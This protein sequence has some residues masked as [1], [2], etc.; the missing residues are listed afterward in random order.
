MLEY[1]SA[2]TA[3]A[4]AGTLQC[5]GSRETQESE[6]ERQDARDSQ[7]TTGYGG[8]VGPAQMVNGGEIQGHQSRGQ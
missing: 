3:R 2:P 1:P 8:R 4:R 6:P 7:G 5:R